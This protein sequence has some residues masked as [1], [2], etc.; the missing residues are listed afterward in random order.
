MNMV[1]M[2]MNRIMSLPSSADIS[3]YTYIHAPRIVGADGESVW[4]VGLNSYYLG[5]YSRSKNKELAADFLAFMADYDQK[6]S[7]AM[8]YDQALLYDIESVNDYPE[9]EWMQVYA[10][11]FMEK[12]YPIYSDAIRNSVLPLFSPQDKD[13]MDDHIS[14]YMI[15]V[16]TLDEL[17]ARLTETA[18]MMLR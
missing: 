8:W 17:I 2:N 10:D 3:V 1:D 9:D 13:A 12:G 15:D 16:I 14:L 6:H 18:E 11:R 7:Y 4:S 5:I